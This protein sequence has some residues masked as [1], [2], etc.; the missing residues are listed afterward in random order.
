[1]PVA[2]AEVTPALDPGAFTLRTAP[3]R[4]SG[5]DPWPGFAEAARP[6]PD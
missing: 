2:W 3:A 4:L 6:L 5:P 1:M